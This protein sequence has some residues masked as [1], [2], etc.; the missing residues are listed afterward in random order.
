MEEIHHCLPYSAEVI[1][2]VVELAHTGAT[3]TKKSILEEQLQMAAHYDISLL[4]KICSNSLSP[5]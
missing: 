2:T 5:L 1:S 4:T 3:T